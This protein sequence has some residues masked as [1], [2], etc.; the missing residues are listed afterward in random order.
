MW[1]R[2]LNE[3][4]LEGRI[5]HE[6]KYEVPMEVADRF[7]QDCLPFCN[8]DPYAGETKM[9]EIASVYYDTPNFI[10]YRDR[11][12]SVG[13]RRKIRLRS[14]NTDGKSIA[15]FIE[16]K[17]KHKQFVNK[18][19]INMKNPRIIDNCPYPH[20]R[21][22]LS[23]VIENLEDS[24]EKREIVYLNKR[25]ELI[26]TTIIRYF[27]KALIP[28]FEDDMR[29]TLDTNI[30]AGGHTL[31]K[32]D[33][34]HEKS[35]LAPDFGVLEVKTNRSIPLWLNAIMQKHQLSQVRYSKYCLGV[36]YDI[37]GKS[38]WFKGCSTIHPIQA[39]ESVSTRMSGNI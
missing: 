11:E 31:D 38:Y 15:L 23:Y 5:R 29:I 30:T 26:P 9:Y 14:Y 3:H 4:A 39:E 6:L 20:H 13:Y 12:E 37:K 32:Q 28:T 33:P 22:P 21:I 19:R 8:W 24:A 34:E 1:K 18:K 2:K 7:F 25:Y 16:I 10:F 17:E 36:D 35:I 27:R